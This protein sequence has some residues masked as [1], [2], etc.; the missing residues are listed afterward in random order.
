MPIAAMSALLNAALYCAGR[1]LPEDELLALLLPLGG[2]RSQ[3]QQLLTQ[4]QQQAPHLGLTLVLQAQGWRYQSHPDLAEQLAP[5]FSERAP[6]MSR[7]QWETLA[8]IAWQQPVTRAQVED[9]RGVALSSG[10]LRSLLDYEWIQVQGHQESP[11]RPALYGTSEQF[12]ADFGLSSL[13]ELPGLLGSEWQQQELPVEAKQMRFSEL[14]EKHLSL[15]R[16]DDSQLFS[17]LQQELSQADELVTQASAWQQQP[18]DDAE[19]ERPAS[20]PEDETPDNII[21]RM[22]A[23]QQALLAKQDR[24]KNAKP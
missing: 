24:S 20:A 23:E 13:Q 9:V 11:G 6:R 22:L 2:T 18:L 7:A 1:P 19:D 14:L 21:K 5:L 10:T 17:H 8:I 3:L 15:Q 4:L 16:Q 12:L